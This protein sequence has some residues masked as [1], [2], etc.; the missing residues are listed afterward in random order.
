MIGELT[1][2]LPA[3]HSPA[4]LPLV[5]A[6]RLIELCFQTAGLWEMRE[7]NKFGLPLHIDQLFVLNSHFAADADLFAVV[8]PRADGGFDAEVVGADGTRYLELRGY[9][10]IAVPAQ[11]DKDS[12][13]PV[14][15]AVA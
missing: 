13:K 10:T 14:E 2:T 8:T 15:M 7:Q 12:L 11:I 3:N 1:R 9:R 4:D 5:C 6:P